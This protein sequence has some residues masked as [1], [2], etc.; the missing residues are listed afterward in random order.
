MTGLLPRQVLVNDL[1]KHI[2]T[3]AKGVSLREPMRGRIIDAMNY[4]RLLA[5]MED[6][7]GPSRITHIEDWRANAKNY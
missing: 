2:L 4:L 7:E 3:I 5:L 1:G 6:S